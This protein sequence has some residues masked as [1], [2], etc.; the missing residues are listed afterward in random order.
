MTKDFWNRHISPD[1]PVFTEELEVRVGKQIG[2]QAT[3]EQKEVFEGIIDGCEKAVNDTLNAKYPDGNWRDDPAFGRIVGK[4]GLDPDGLEIKTELASVF[5]LETYCPDYRRIVEET[6][7]ALH[8][9]F[10]HDR[11]YFH[12]DLSRTFRNMILRGDAAGV[13]SAFLKQKPCPLTVAL[14]NRLLVHERL[15]RLIALTLRL[16]YP[17]GGR[18][19]P[20]GESLKNLLSLFDEEAVEIALELRPPSG[21]EE[22]YKEYNGDKKLAE[23]IA[24]G[25]D[26]E[27]L[28]QY[29]KSVLEADS[30]MII[31]S[32]ELNAARL[33]ACIRSCAEK[34]SAAY[35]YLLDSG[36]DGVGGIGGDG[37]GGIGG[38]GVGVGVGDSGGVGDFGGAAGDG[39]ADN[40]DHK[41]VEPGV[42]ERNKSIAVAIRSVIDDLSKLD[43]EYYDLL[44]PAAERPV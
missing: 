12:P 40:D 25:L 9:E 7:H 37:V 10:G 16:A 4:L 34:M 41:T 19:N 6:G 43:L 23:M 21:G 22:N 30:K 20:E 27:T 13:R 24:G 38:D 33:T 15:L 32:R 14:G 11:V 35:S 17:R 3:E 29:A 2:E 31:G 26:D 8:K 5:W 1:S 44:P 39:A 42:V 18:W 28:V 36:G